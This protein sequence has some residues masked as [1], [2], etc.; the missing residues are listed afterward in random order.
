MIVREARS[1]LGRFLLLPLSSPARGPLR[2][3]SRPASARGPL[4]GAREAGSVHGA[5]RT[6]AR[7]LGSGG[8]QVAAE[9]MP[10]HRHQRPE[11]NTSL[12]RPGRGCR[13][14]HRSPP[15]CGQRGRCDPD[16]APIGAVATGGAPP[17]R[18]TTRRR[19]KPD[20][21][22]PDYRPAR[23]AAP[24]SGRAPGQKGMSRRRGR[25]RRVTSS[26]TAPAVLRDRA[27]GA[28]QDLIKESE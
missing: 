20:P 8:A 5:W 9:A 3:V 1:D 11:C 26:K 28:L 24:S 19:G 7:S 18:G 13:A 23:R 17:L 16:R 25:G 27:G 6:T 2:P 14:S 10:Y 12:P 22:G 15:P 4:S 21:N